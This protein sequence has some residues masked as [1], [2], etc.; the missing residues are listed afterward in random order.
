MNFSKNKKKVT[1]KNRFTIYD[2]QYTKKGFTLIELLIVCAII[3]VLVVVAVVSYS[4]SKA[5]ARDSKRKADVAIVASA[6]Q[7]YYE[8]NKTY[9][10]SGTGWIDPDYSDLGGT[11]IGFLNLNATNNVDDFMYANTSIAKGLVDAGFLS[12]ET[13]DSGSFEYMFNYTSSG[14]I[15]ASVY[16]RLE[17]AP[18][19]LPSGTAYDYYIGD[20]DPEGADYEMNYAITITP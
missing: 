16:T 2:I 17:N 10:I 4:A 1:A 11:G 18:A 8:Q 3:A 9:F 6:F 15:K 12:N 7:M 5:K 19:T 14:N 13:I 20:T